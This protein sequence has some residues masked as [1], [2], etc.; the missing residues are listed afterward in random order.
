MILTFSRQVL[1]NPA[2][3]DAFS[4]CQSLTLSSVS[5]STCF[6]TA[7]IM[8]EGDFTALMMFLVCVIQKL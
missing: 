1:F 8:Q 3:I 2:V 4:V 7:V 5:F 6:S